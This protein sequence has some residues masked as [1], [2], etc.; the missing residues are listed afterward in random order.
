LKHGESRLRVLAFRSRFVLTLGYF[1]DGPQRGGVIGPAAKV[2]QDGNSAF[3]FNR[4]MLLH[5]WSLYRMSELLA[6]VV[7]LNLGAQML[8]VADSTGVGSLRVN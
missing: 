1:I 2:H 6:E 8:P 4:D 7:E 5:W 3:S